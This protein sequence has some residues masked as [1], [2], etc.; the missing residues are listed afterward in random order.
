[1]P[2]IPSSST[3]ASTWPSPSRSRTGSSPPSSATPQKKS[4]REINEIVKDLA[5][6]ARTK[7]LKPE[8][9]QGGTLTVSN[10]GSYGIDS[11]SAIINPPQALILSIGAIVKKPVIDSKGQIVAGQRMNIGLSCDHRVVDG[12]IGAEYLAELRRLIEN[13]ALMLI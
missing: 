9:Y 6:R 4:L 8:E 5:T 11:F 10:L 2:A 7:K 1:M 13:P 3:P 12:A